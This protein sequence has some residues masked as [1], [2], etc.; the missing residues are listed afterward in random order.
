MPKKVF[1]K[2]YED[3]VNDIGRNYKTGDRYLTVRGIA[4]KFSVSLQTAQ[5][6]VKELAAAGIVSSKSKAGI[7]VQNKHYTSSTFSGR[8]IKVISNKDDGNFYSA[9]YDGVKLVAGPLGVKT[10]F[11]INTFPDIKSLAFGEYLVSLKADG[12][13]MLS[14]ADSDLPFYHVLREGVDIVSDVISDDLPLLPSIQTDNRK[15]ARE[16]GEELSEKASG[17]LYVYGYNEKANTKSF[18]GFQE[19][20]KGSGREAAYVNMSSIYSMNN[21]TEIIKNLTEDD[22]IFI[23][24]YASTYVIDMLCS[25]NGIKPAHMLAYDTDSGFYYSDFLPPIKT[26]AP[27][28]TTLGMKLCSVIINKWATGEYEEPLQRKI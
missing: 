12:L 17:R 16:A 5:K 25:R 26:V 11:M 2:F 13:V 24:D 23:S 22:G 21:A 20:L 14:F 4:E 8:T 3:M 27:S 1:D 28:F 6:G 10:E 19:A 9:F 7:I 18:L 15:H